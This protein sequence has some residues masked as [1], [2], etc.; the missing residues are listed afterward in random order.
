MFREF[1]RLIWLLVKVA[2]IVWIAMY[3]SALAMT[4]AFIEK[5]PQMCE[6]VYERD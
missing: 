1:L 2:V 6:T 3:I 4:R 5:L